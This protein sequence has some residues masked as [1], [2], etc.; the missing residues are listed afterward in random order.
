[1]GLPLVENGRVNNRFEPYAVLHNDSCVES[2]NAKVR[3]VLGA[4][5]H[6]RQLDRIDDRSVVNELGLCNSLIRVSTGHQRDELGLTLRE[7]LSRIR[8][9]LLGRLS[10]LL[11]SLAVRLIFAERLLW[12]SCCT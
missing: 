5:V 8:E 11:F 10:H 3:H 9:Y 7:C 6:A 12:R 2:E 4:A 1:M